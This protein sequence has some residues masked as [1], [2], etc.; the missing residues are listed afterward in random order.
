VKGF[1]SRE[2]LGRFA[3][4]ASGRAEQ[5]RRRGVSFFAASAET[6]PLPRV[7][8]GRVTASVWE[9][10]HNEGVDDARSNL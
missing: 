10:I 7:P 8:S 1:I 9:V 4:S 2:A 5:A 6:K 3:L